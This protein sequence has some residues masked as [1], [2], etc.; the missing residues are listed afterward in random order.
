MRKSKTCFLECTSHCI[1]AECVLRVYYVPLLSNVFLPL[2]TLSSGGVLRCSS[3]SP[4]ST[5][6]LI[7]VELAVVTPV[8]R[9]TFVS[10]APATRKSKIGPIFFQNIFLLYI[11][12]V[13]K[14]KTG[15]KTAKNCQKKLFFLA[16]PAIWLSSTW[17][18]PDHIRSD[19][20][21]SGPYQVRPNMVQTMSGLTWY[22]TNHIK[23]SLNRSRP[24]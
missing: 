24:N 17:F 10:V 9:R 12:L 4:N 15:Q 21:W 11:F 5:V 1:L 6:F 22:G 3:W 20:I 2:L 13:K 7:F 8:E 19:L 14:Q 18:G 16:P 23:P